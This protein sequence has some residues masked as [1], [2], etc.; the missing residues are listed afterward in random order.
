[1]VDYSKYKEIEDELSKLID[2]GYKLMKLLSNNHSNNNSYLKK[3]YNNNRHKFTFEYQDWYTRSLPVIRHLLPER[4]DE[5]ER[6]Y[7]MDS[8]SYIDKSTYTIEDYIQGMQI[9]DYVR[10]Y[11]D[12][13]AW[14]R[15][16]NQVSIVNSAFSRLNSL[17]ANLNELVHANIFND[18]LEMA[19]YLQK[20]GYKDS[21]AV[22]AGGT[23]EEHLRKLCQKNDIKIMKDN[24]Y[25]RKAESLNAD[26]AGANVYSKLNQKSITA[27]LDLRN[28]AAHGKYDEYTKDQV[29][30]MVQ[31]I[32]D[33]ISRNPA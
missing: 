30:L 24:S 25:H 14:Y 31:S 22:L 10:N 6:S 1:M 19:D 16:R 23:L 3:N 28:K 21:A 26:L 2:D 15:L 5:F 32:L 20:E 33:F 13:I 18:F 11:V 17:L 4:L 8:R 12:K 7:H 9:N 29:A 27:L